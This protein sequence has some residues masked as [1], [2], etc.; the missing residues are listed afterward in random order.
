MMAII[1]VGGV[2]GRCPNSGAIPS[3]NH[4]EKYGENHRKIIENHRKS[5]QK[6]DDEVPNWMVFMENPTKNMEQMMKVAAFSMFS[7]EARCWSMNS[8]GDYIYYPL[9]P[10]ISRGLVH[11]PRTGE[12]LFEPSSFL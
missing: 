9:L 11:N 2:A 8:L 10:F 3:K 5:H 4:G 7:L 6:M 1:S 12:S